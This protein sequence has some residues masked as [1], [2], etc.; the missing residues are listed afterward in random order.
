[1]NVVKSGQA[2]EQQTAR[3]AKN[4]EQRFLRM[5]A[6]VIFEHVAQGNLDAA[7]ASLTLGRRMISASA[8]RRQALAVRCVT[9]GQ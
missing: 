8:K 3:Q 7:G 1:M 6:A 5:L 2:Q 9:S 4:R